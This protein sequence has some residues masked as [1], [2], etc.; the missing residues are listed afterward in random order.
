MRKMPRHSPNDRRRARCC[1]GPSGGA[2]GREEALRSIES[3]RLQL[4]G[5]IWP[6]LQMPTPEP[7]FTSGFMRETLLIDFK[8]N[9]LRLEQQ[10]HRRGFRESQC[11]HHYCRRRHRLR[12][13]RSHRDADPGRAIES[14][15]IRSVLSTSSEPAASVRP[16][17][18]R[19]R[20]VHLDAIRS[21]VGN[22]M[23]SRSSC[24]T[25]NKWLCMSIRRPSS[26]PNM[27]SSPSIRSRARTHRRSSSATTPHSAKFRVPQSWNQ[28]LA[29]DAVSKFKL[30]AEI[31]PS[32]NDASFAAPTGSFVKVDALPDA[33]KE[34]VEKLADGVFILH[35]VAEQNYNTLAIAMKDH[36]VVIEAPGS[37]AGAERA[38]KQIKEAIPGKPIRYVAMTHHH[39]DHIGGLRS[40]IAEGAK[41]I[42]TPANR[43]IVE[44]MAAAPQIDRLAKNPRKPEFSAD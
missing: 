6:R 34:E 15:A 2:I 40:F 28:R 21:T 7:P 43:S 14:T 9:R 35:N 23:C 13:S 10:T 39:S 22:T 42:T 5:D 24:P 25:H 31:N 36:I 18:V 33:L 38:L 20:C 4:E 19:I 27:S 8:N 26:Y 37:S 44:A 17:I 32:I 12:S 1:A 30:R 16:S 3:V 29:G 11:D 41:V